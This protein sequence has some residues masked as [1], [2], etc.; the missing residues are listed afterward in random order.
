MM[1][2][3]DHIRERE[4]HVNRNP[5]EK[6]KSA[7]N[8]R[9][10][11]LKA[12]G[13]D[14]AIENPRGSIRSGK[15][16]DGKEWSVRMPVSYGYI[17]RTEGTDGDAVDVFLGPHLKS[18]KIF[19][20]DQMDA[21]SGEHDEHKVF[22]GFA[23]HQQVLKAYRAAFSD[24]KA[25]KRLGHM[26]EMTPEEFKTW[27]RNDGAAKPVIERADGGRVEYADGGAPYKG[28]NLG[29][30]SAE[31]AIPSWDESQPV[32]APAWDQ[33]QEVVPDKG[34]L[35]AFGRGA[36]QGVTMNFGDELRGLGEVGGVKPEE[37]NDPIS[38]IRGGYRYFT[39]EPGAEE[40]YNAA[41]KRE[42]A[43]D[44][45]TAEAHPWAYHG[46]EFAGAV[47]PMM[48][49][50]GGALAEGANF[51]TRVG[52]GVRA[53]ATYGALS[54]AGEGEDA[55]SRVL[56]AG[57]GTLTGGVGGGAAVPI[58]EG[59]GLAVK[60]MLGPAWNGVVSLAR[61]SENEAARRVFSAIEADS[62][63]IAA[64]KMKGMSVQDWLQ[65]RAA[66]EPVM[67]ADLGGA[68]TQSILRSAA[69]TSPEGRGVLEKSLEDRFAGQ[70]DRVAADVRNLVQG[71]ANAGKRADQL[72]AEYDA[73]RAPL[74]Q[75][76]FAQPSAQQLWTPE[77]QQMAE[78]PLVQQAMRM[79][80]MT[81]RNEAAKLGL[82]QPI[83][84]FTFNRDGS[85]ALTNPAL[86]P[87]L[88]YWDVVKKNLDGGDR[89]AQQWAKAL[90]QHLD[91]HV[92][93]Y[94]DARG[95]AANFFGERDALEA[96]R[97]MAGKNMDPEVIAKAM[98]KMDPDEKDLFR[99]GYA[100]DWANRVIGNF[101]DSRDITKAMFNSPNERKRAEIIFGPA[102]VKTL[103]NRMTLETVMDG[104]RKA[105]GNSTTARQLIEAGLAG[106]ALGYYEGGDW[107]SAMTGAG[108]AAGARRALATEMASGARHL[109]GKVDAKT[110]ARVAELLTSDD[111]RKL[112]Q[113]L[114][115]MNANQAVA[116]GMRNIANRMAVAGQSPASGTAAALPYRGV[117]LGPLAPASAD[118]NQ[119]QP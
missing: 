83:N 12:H 17:K 40:A 48:A 106:G 37:W 53:G 11:H 92:P 119:Q 56:N 94:A 50:P 101:R 113:G 28:E 5:S 109:I 112:A 79:A 51:A 82:P 13:F 52:Q 36:Y 26:T 29:P 108:M 60:K 86:Q 54:G 46:G 8:Y 20:L 104:A 23:S 107:K 47:A 44:K 9:K 2:M 57:V 117:N 102:G 19:V 91:E 3:V 70:A 65:A 93:S 15:G 97:A 22:F 69:N 85:V 84:P 16:A 27:L 116:N 72:V 105:M 34:A 49:V 33:T 98:R 7:G 30:L 18:P 99:E 41:V 68:R 62:H 31:G 43:E 90:R 55:G 14:I 1:S 87:N 66:G 74:Y 103:E 35:N 88:Q 73:G 67:L 4:S 81:G 38:T 111:P 118:Q 10:A 80:T 58:S 64:G 100:S 110:A 95:F 45:A 25:D 76:A 21:D 59:V 63:D 78:A 6:Q 39:G 32:E 71:G 96:G 89:N 75:R 42:R 24:G 115:I 114:R 61:G 77:L